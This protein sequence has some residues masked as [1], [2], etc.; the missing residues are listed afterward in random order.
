MKLTI[1]PLSPD[2][3]SAFEDLFG[4]HGAWNGCWCMYWRIGRE[5]IKRRRQLNKRAF[6]RIVNAGPSPGLLAFDGEV[7]VGWCQLTPRSDL[8]YLN[9]KPSLRPVDDLPVWSITCFFVSR[10]YRG[11]GVMTALIKAAIKWAKRSGAIAVEAYPVD[12]N[13]PHA[14][15]DVFTGMA[16]AFSRA[17][18][19]TVARRIPSRPIMRYEFKSRRPGRAAVHRKTRS[20]TDA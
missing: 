20:G 3:W 18:F 10:G 15:T 11:K 2:L 7:A 16:S 12:T 1:R 8:P 6:H 13:Q 17:G 4:E 5:I 14:S 9:S 19:R